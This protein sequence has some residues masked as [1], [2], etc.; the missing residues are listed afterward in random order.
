[1]TYPKQLGSNFSLKWEMNENIKSPVSNGQIVGKCKV[2]VGDK[3]VGEKDVMSL[4]SN[5]KGNILRVAY[6]SIAHK[7]QDIV[8]Y[9]S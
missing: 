9:V 2:L 3:V 8:S 1:M 6:D 7:W 4:T 5:P